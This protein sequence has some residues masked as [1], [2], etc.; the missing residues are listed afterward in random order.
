LSHIDDRDALAGTICRIA[1]EL[2]GGTGTAL[3]QPGPGRLLVLGHHGIHPAPA[4]PELGVSSALER[5]LRGGRLQ[6]GDPL[7]VPLTG[8]TGVVGAASIAHP[9][10]L[11]DPFTLTLLS[12]FGWAAGSSLERY[13]AIVDTAGRDPITGVGDRALGTTAMASLHIGDA[14][15]VSE[16]AGVAAIRRQDGDEAADLVQGHLGLHL[17]NAIRPGDVVARSGDEGFV[18]VLRDVQGP[19]ELIVRRILDTWAVEHPNRRLHVGVAL[20]TPRSAPMDTAE[21]ARA[22][23]FAAQRAQ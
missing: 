4:D 23:L 3:F 5:I 16:V 11:L 13:G 18:V 19:V 8:S 15:V 6:V 20:H 22:A 2:A 17:R 7:I 12:L 10:R 21:S 1:T 14:V 9:Q